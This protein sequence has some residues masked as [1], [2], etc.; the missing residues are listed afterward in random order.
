MEYG[1]PIRLKIG[2]WQG[3]KRFHRNYFLVDSEME[4]KGKLI[5]L[6][7]P[8]HRFVDEV[9]K[10]PVNQQRLVIEGKAII[11]LEKLPL[12]VN[13]GMKINSV[14]KIVTKS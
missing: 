2:D 6:C 8:Y 11:E 1:S 13:H 9:R 5:Q 7:V 3:A 14:E 12:N 4:Y 10:L